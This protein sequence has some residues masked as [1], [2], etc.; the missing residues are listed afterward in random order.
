MRIFLC[1]S[2]PNFDVVIPSIKNSRPILSYSKLF[3]IRKE[4]LLENVNNY[5][6]RVPQIFQTLS[7]MTL[8]NF[9]C[10]SSLWVIM[11]FEAD[12]INTESNRD[13]WKECDT[14]RTTFNEVQTI[15]KLFKA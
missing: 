15:F 12:I 10:K 11:L 1:V 2:N 13:Q 8:K 3:P 14:Y 7:I 5:L 6:L 4:L 9:A